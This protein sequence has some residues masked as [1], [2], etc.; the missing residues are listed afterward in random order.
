MISSGKLDLGAIK[1]LVNRIDVLATTIF[2]WILGPVLMSAWRWHLLLKGIRLSV[3]YVR[4]LSLQMI[5]IF[6]NSAMPGAVGGDIIKAVYVMRD[7]HT[8]QK[9]PAMVTILLDRIVGL[10]GL[11]TIGVV[12][13]LANIDRFWNNPLTKSLVI[14]TMAIFAG[15]VLV[16]AAMLV[17]YPSG[18]DPFIRIFQ[19]KVPGFSVLHKIYEALRF[20]RNAPGYLVKAWLISI[21]MQLVFMTYMWFLTI[22]VTG[23]QVDLALIGTVYPLGALTTALPLAPGGLGIG[24]VAF[25]KLYATIGLSHGATVFNVYFLGQI[26]L[27]MLGVIPYLMAKGKIAHPAAVVDQMQE[28]RANA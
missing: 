3:P 1:I 6:F 22:V 28:D 19:L 18:K 2:V 21:G 27:N 26:V 25:D 23:Q 16:F 17:K 11:F 4:T 8:K 15:M 5:G 14:M 12:A 7:H 13:V 20:Y 9:T 24:H 10:M